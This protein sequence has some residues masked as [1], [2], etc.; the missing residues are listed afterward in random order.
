MIEQMW[1]EWFEH[2]GDDEAIAVVAV[3]LEDGYTVEGR[4]YC[5]LA[6]SEWSR[7]SALQAA[8]AGAAAKLEQADWGGRLS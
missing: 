1:N 2:F 5:G 3:V 8:R 4:A 7:E 6:W